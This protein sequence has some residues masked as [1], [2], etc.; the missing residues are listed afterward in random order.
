MK[1][2]VVENYRFPGIPWLVYGR[3]L[4]EVRAG[5]ILP[6]K[7]FGEKLILD[8]TDSGQTR[9]TGAYCPH[10]GAHLGAGKVEGENLRCALHGFEFGGDGRCVKTAYGKGVPRKAKLATWPLREHNGYIFAWYHPE[11][12]QPDWEVPVLPGPAEGWTAFSTRTI[13]V[14][15]HP[16]ETSENSVD[17]GHFVQFTASAAPGPKGTSRLMAIC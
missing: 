17:I 1:D 2:T 6:V 7:Y 16:Q 9:L 14:N 10:P 12:Q 13:A 4:K 3:H 11:G 5:Q 15:S 8:P